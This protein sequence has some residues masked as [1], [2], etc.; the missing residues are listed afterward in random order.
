[1]AIEQQPTLPDVASP[2]NIGEPQNLTRQDIVEVLNSYRLEAQQ[3]RKHGPTGRDAVWEANVNLYWNN[4]DYSKKASWQSK[5]IMPEAPI[6]VDR[7]ASAMRDALVLAGEWYTVEDPK[8]TEGDLARSIK[9]FIDVWL[10]RCGRNATG[11]PMDFNAVF[12]EQMKLAAMMAGVAAVTWKRDSEGRGYVAIE[13]VDPREV[14]LDPTGRGLYRVRRYPIDLHQLKTLAELKDSAGEPIYDRQEIMQLESVQMTDEEMQRAQL[15]GHGRDT[16]SPRKTIT[17]DEYLCTLLDRQGNKIA[18][19]VLAVVANERFLIRTPEPN[20]FWHKKDWIVYA[21]AISVPLSTYGRSYMENW[22]SVARTYIAMTNLIMDA[23]F[24]TSIKAFVTVPDMLE[25]PT[26]MEE[27]VFPAKTFQLEAGGD[28][29]QFLAAVDLG[30]LSSGSVQVWSALKQILR[31][32]ASFNEIALGQSPPKGDI[33]A[34]E[35]A[36]TEQ[37]STALQRAIAQTIEARFLEPTLELVWKI[38]LQHMDEGDEELRDA[39][40]EETFNMFLDRAEELA[41][42]RITFQARGLS[43]LIER[44]QKLRALMS[45][46]QIMG[47]NPAFAQVLFQKIEPSKLVDEMLRLLGI[48]TL[49]LRSSPRE[50][51]VASISGEP[52]RLRQALGGDDEPVTQGD[53]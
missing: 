51:Q 26:E 45:A 20:P 40:G 18:D 35:I 38:G 27:G 7:W 44:Q 41:R 33:T 6:F 32:G 31:E 4:I 17:I 34:T 8:D 3:A 2:E 29:R 12:E 42:R 19:N 30:S 11:Q 24:L 47:S 53:A 52:R 10:K 43:S 15:A 48:D 9:K 13:A 28:A 22:A 5:E 14:W 46:L 16:T 39:L 25:D 37:G 50:Q 23:V 1:M 49:K 21:P 36:A